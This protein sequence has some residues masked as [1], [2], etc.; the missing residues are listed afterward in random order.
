MPLPNIKNRVGNA[1]S[2][3][4]GTGTITLSS[5]EAGYQSFATA[6]GAN[7]NVDILIEEGDAWE[8]AR[9]CTYTHSG[10]TVTRGTL[11]ASSTGSAV[12]FTSAA[13]VY[14][15]ES[16]ERVARP[17]LTLSTVS[18][19]G[20]LTLTSGV[21]VTTSNVLDAS[22]I[23][24]TPHVH[25]I[26]CLWDGADWVPNVFSEVSIAVG[27]VITERPYDIFGYLSSGALA[28]EMVAWTSQT[29]RA[30]DISLEDGRYVKSGSKTHLLLGTVCASSTTGIDDSTNRRFVS[31]TYNAVNKTSAM[32]LT[33]ENNHTYST[34]TWRAFNNSSNARFLF[35]SWIGSILF[36][37][38]ISF[39]GSNVGG[40]GGVGLN[41]TTTTSVNISSNSGGSQRATGR[42][43]CG[44]GYNYASLNQISYG[45]A[46]YNWPSLSGVITC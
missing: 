42:V 26:I 6:Y 14:V 18:P 29:V 8:I 7:A 45:S 33:G 31:N 36:D 41:T 21:P 46:T 1:V 11:E 20:R 9:D 44:L 38:A 35:V 12:S 2:G 27:T 15:I 23:Y 16:A 28:L 22:T 30:T 39:N 10:T 4:P 19:G 40:V 24:Y 37:V 25:N 32:I 43:A 3:T 5:A 17:N 34:A 13:K